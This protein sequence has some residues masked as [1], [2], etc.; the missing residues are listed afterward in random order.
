[1]LGSTL[2]RAVGPDEE[3]LILF[4]KSVPSWESDITE[5]FESSPM[6]LT[7]VSDLKYY[8]THVFLR[9]NYFFFGKNLGERDVLV[10]KIH[11]Q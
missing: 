7:G 2:A 4:V 11:S 6:A 3:G 9:Q 5:W 10:I 1:M 8:K